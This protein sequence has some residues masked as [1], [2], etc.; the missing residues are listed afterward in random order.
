MEEKKIKW[1]RK[2]ALKAERKKKEE[3]EEKEKNGEYEGDDTDEMIKKQKMDGSVEGEDAATMETS[4]SPEDNDDKEKV[5]ADDD[6][7]E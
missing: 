7:M 3:E 1:E 2:Q 6:P 5:P 4:V